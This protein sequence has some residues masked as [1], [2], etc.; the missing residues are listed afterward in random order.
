[1]IS[2]SDERCFQVCMVEGGNVVQRRGGGR[3]ALKGKI[4]EE[5]RPGGGL[6][7]VFIVG[8]AHMEG[9]S[10]EMRRK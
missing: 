5:T 9:E 4:R 2:S 6:F 10:D 8:C 7:W 1:M 3:R